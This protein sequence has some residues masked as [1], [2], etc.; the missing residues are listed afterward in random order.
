MSGA[1]SVPTVPEGSGLDGTGGGQGDR[2][3]EVVNG[4]SPHKEMK[5]NG[6][7]EEMPV[8]APR[9]PHPP[10]E[11]AGSSDWDLLTCR[12][13]QLSQGRVPSTAGARS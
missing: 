4:L 10:D 12:G 7:P 6:L 9:S 2:A 11:S 5:G 8:A 3:R 1:A 13:R